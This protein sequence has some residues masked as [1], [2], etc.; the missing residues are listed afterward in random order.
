MT[1]V[2]VSNYNNTFVMVG[3]VS[4]YDKSIVIVRNS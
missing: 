3:L 2:T 4:D 1:L